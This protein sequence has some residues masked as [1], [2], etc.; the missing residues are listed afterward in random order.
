MFGGNQGRSVLNLLDYQHQIK[1]TELNWQGLPC[2]LRIRHYKT[3]LE[4]SDKQ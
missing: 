1:F 4:P 2:M 3:V